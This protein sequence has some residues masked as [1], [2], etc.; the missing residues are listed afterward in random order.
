VFKGKNQERA[1]QQHRTKEKKERVSEVSA[2]ISF[3]A[4][5]LFSSTTFSILRSENHYVPYHNITEAKKQV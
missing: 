4:S 3:A 1:V 5:S 2:S